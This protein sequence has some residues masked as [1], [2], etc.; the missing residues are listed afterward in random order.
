MEIISRVIEKYFKYMNQINGN[1]FIEEL[2]PEELLNN[3]KISKH[4]GIRHWKP[5][6][7]TVRNSEIFQL[8][9][10]FQHRL[11][12]S[13][14][15]FLQFVHYIELHLGQHSIG[16]FKNLPNSLVDDTKE[17]IQE[18]YPELLDKGLIPFARAS[19]YAAVCFDTNTVVTNYDYRIVLV[20][21]ELG[22]VE[23]FSLNFEQMF[24][25]FENH[26]EQWISSNRQ[27]K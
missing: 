3:V 16:F 15:F 5:I 8:E 7:S 6:A 10:Y 23:H 18:F 19:D 12:D 11:P 24:I 17:E 13:Y 25:E 22:D 4:D 27:N 20:S 26:L 9:E 21:E 1:S 2:I 14:K